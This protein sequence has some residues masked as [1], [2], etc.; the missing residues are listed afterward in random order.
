MGDFFARVRPTLFIVLVSFA[1]VAVVVLFDRQRREPEPIEIDFST[2]VQREIRV[3]VVGRV[4]SPG[5]YTL[6]AGDRVEE[7]LRLAG[8]PL[9]DADLSRINRASLLVDGQQIRVPAQGET[10]PG[11]LIDLNTAPASVIETLPSIGERRAE[12]IVASRETLGPFM[13]LEE[14]VERRLVPA[15]VIEEIRPYVALTP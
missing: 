2:P 4:A 3:E 6:Y 14:L 11:T 7:A 9:P 8:D 12:R 5:V 10:I 15:G 13:R 1:V